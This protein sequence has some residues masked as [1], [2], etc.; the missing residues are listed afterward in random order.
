[1]N[2]SEHYYRGEKNWTNF[3]PSHEKI[4]YW[5]LF[6]RS[7]TVRTCRKWSIRGVQN[8]RAL[9]PNTPI[10]GSLCG[11]C[12]CFQPTPQRGYPMAKS[13]SVDPLGTSFCLEV[14]ARN[15]TQ[16]E[17]AR[18]RGRIRTTPYQHSID[19]LHNTVIL[20]KRFSIKAGFFWRVIIPPL[21]RIHF[22]ATIIETSIW[23]T[24]TICSTGRINNNFLR[25]IESI[26]RGW[27]SS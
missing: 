27:Y 21:L 1:M 2:K 20:M 25:K 18:K 15:D 9:A 13:Y 16:R 26:D 19:S 3:C 22:T 24:R 8:E 12:N 5:P 14:E 6:I 7:S 11:G 23:N 10:L 17:V 4:K